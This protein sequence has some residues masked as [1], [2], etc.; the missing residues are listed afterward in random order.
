MQIKRIFIN[1]AQLLA[2]VVPKGENNSEYNG[3]ESQ[4]KMETKKKWDGLS[5][6]VRILGLL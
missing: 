1:S 5:F 2:N 3:T 4:N 6:F